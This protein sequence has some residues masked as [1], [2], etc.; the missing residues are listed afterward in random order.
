MKHKFNYYLILPASLLIAEVINISVFYLLSAFFH[1]DKLNYLIVSIISIAGYYIIGNCF[2]R[3][4]ITENAQKISVV[5]TIVTIL[6]SY[7]FVDVLSFYG[8]DY[9]L[10]HLA[11]GSP[12]ANYT[13]YF[14]NINKHAYLYEIIVTVLSPVSVVLIAFFEKLGRRNKKA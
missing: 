6:L 4:I 10:F 12:V 13:T 11:F 14:F 8:I 9:F 5:I 2:Y 1:N 3:K 7:I